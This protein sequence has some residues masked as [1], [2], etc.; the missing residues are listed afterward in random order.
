MRV[1]VPAREDF[2]LTALGPPQA[3]RPVPGCNPVVIK[4]PIHLHR[5]RPSLHGNPCPRAAGEI[6]D[7]RQA[8]CRLST[9]AKAC[10]R[11]GSDSATVSGNSP[12]SRQHSDVPDRGMPHTG[13]TPP[14]GSYGSPWAVAPRRSRRP[15][16]R[17]PL[18]PAPEPQRASTR[19]RARCCA[20][21]VSDRLRRCGS[22][23]RRRRRPPPR[24]IVGP[25]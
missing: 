16:K 25:Q 20:M 5:R 2:P 21:V 11:M 12:A 17:L 8:S 24:R 19:G 10:R 15:A 22:L 4:A 1:C 13:R 23:L 6:L 3:L 14:Q 7:S 9:P 18:A